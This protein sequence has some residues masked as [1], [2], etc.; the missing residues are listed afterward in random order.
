MAASIL[1]QEVTEHLEAA[2]HLSNRRVLLRFLDEAEVLLALNLP[3]AAILVAG[4]VL[5]SIVAAG[6]EQGSPDERQQIGN[7]LELRNSVA[8]A[9]APSL[10]ADQVKEMVEGIR[11]FLIRDVSVGQ[12]F[13]TAQTL[14]ETPAQLRGKYK[15]VPTSSAEFIRRKADELRLEHDEHGF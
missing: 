10:A 9:G 1:P 4:V 2:I 11:G 5:E 15:F 8:H 3:V 6:Q 13:V 12:R 14:A 7:W